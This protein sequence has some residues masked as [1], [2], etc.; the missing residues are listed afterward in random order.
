MTIIQGLFKIL[1]ILI[2]ISSIKNELRIPFKTEKY[3]NFSKNLSNENN[4]KNYLISLVHNDIYI[5]LEIGSPISQKIKSF[6]KLEEYP[7]FIQGKDIPFS[8][9][10]ESKSL[11]Y[12]SELYP[13]V[14][15]DGEEQ[16][17]WGYVS[18]DTITFHNKTKKDEISL[19][20]FNFVLVTETK[21]DSCSNIGL[22]IP[23]QYTSIPEISFIYQLKKQNIIDFYSFVINYTSYEQEEG[24][25]IIGGP[26]HLYDNK[27]SDKFYETQ[28]AIDKPKYMMYG[29]EFNSI[30]Y[31]NNRTNIGGSLQSK[32]LSDFGL[33][34]GTNAYYEIVYEKFFSK[35]IL[36]EICFKS[37]IKLNIEWREGEKNFEF[38]YCEKNKVDI[39][40]ME[41]IK[42]IHK[43]MN[44]TFEFN[45][46]E[47][48]KETDNYYIFKIIFPKSNNFYWIFGKIWLEKYLMVF[49]QDKKTIG[50]YYLEKEIK[51]DNDKNNSE[52]LLIIII[53]FLLLIAVSLIIWFVY[54]FKNENRKRRLNEI[55]EEYEYSQENHGTENLINNE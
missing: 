31:G 23:N 52:I 10:D 42:F 28:N 49:D 25:F 27:Y 50:H 6:I 22:M 19:K 30:N 12:K 24:E 54:Y 37:E 36:N 20:E 43:R 3:T 38:F 26:P 33:I 53:G 47:L 18:N 15:L 9:Y 40:K 55:N 44:F 13:H 46:N 48:F 34:A 1:I 45:H 11:T 51:D 4:I 5:E 41:N 16:I 14:F 39:S 21:T 29:L 7:F 2:L 32:F 17:K 8:E 35:Y